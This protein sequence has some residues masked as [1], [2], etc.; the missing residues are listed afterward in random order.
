MIAT[1]TSGLLMRLGASVPDGTCWTAFYTSPRSMGFALIRYAIYSPPCPPSCH[2]CLK[3]SWAESASCGCQ[4]V[5]VNQCVIDPRCHPLG[6]TT[7]LS[8]S[9]CNLV[10]SR[11]GGPTAPK[12]CGHSYWLVARWPR[13]GG[14]SGAGTHFMPE[15]SM[16]FGEPSRFRFSPCNLL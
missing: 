1:N 3:P 2:D 5:G 11:V 13:Y 8:V 10:D 9:A 12:R 4:L 7:R 6:A 14:D 15:A 16:L